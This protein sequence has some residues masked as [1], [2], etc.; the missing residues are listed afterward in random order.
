MPPSE[1]GP[2]GQHAVPLPSEVSPVGPSARLRPE[3]IS[4]VIQKA[5]LQLASETLSSQRLLYS[6]LQALREEREDLVPSLIANLVPIR[7]PLT[8]GRSG[9][10]VGEHALVFR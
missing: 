1:S 5:D 7:R 3:V 6:R 10:K 2:R 9:H 4:E 8:A